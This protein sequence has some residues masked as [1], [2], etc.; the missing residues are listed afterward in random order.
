VSDQFIYN[1]EVDTINTQI[2][3]RSLSWLSTGTPIT[4]AWISLIFWI[5]I[6]PLCEIMRSCKCHSH[7][8][9]M[10]ILTY[11]RVYSVI[12]KKKRLTNQTVLI[13]DS[14]LI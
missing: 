11:N 3:H 6:P 13:S 2:H 7:V 14:D 10:S 9:N 1:R 5:Q 8:S 12:I 4:S